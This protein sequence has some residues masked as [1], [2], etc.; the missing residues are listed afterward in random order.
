M[1]RSIASALPSLATFFSLTLGVL[2][3]ILLFEH[4]FFIAALLIL[5]GALC[6]GLDGA[7]AHHLNAASSI[8]KELDSL[9]DMVTFG[10]AP[11]LLVYNLMTMVGLSV[12]LAA[13]T[14]LFFVWGGAFRLARYNTLP[15]TREDDFTGLPIPAACFLIITGAFWQHWAVELWWTG[16]VVVTSFL[17]ISPFPYSKLK[18]FVTLP[19][20]F[21]PGAAALLAV[22]WLLAGW[23][24]LPFGVL[25]VYGLSGPARWLYLSTRRRF[26][27]G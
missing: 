18:H 9:A 14:S 23:Q 2:A 4:S 17:M 16:V 26:S 25:A 19:P 7:L 3:I 15:S 12:P 20:L 5:A 6:D 13:L 21:W 10:V 27:L 22:L 24:A 8:G 1:P 11:T